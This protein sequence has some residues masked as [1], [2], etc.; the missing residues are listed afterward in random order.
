MRRVILIHGAGIPQMDA[1][2]G[3]WQSG[4]Q[5]ALGSGYE[6]LRPQMP[7]PENPHYE[8]WKARVEALLREARHEVVLVGHSLGGVVL[9]KYLAE[10]DVGSHI[11]G[12]FA[13]A[14]PWFGGEDKDWDVPQFALRDDLTRLERVP[15]ILLYHSRDDEVVPFAHLAI[16]GKHLPHATVRPFDDRGHYFNSRDF[17]EIIADIKG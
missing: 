3:D 7:D 16:Y 15:R 4:L 2:S 8:A 13:V 10:N 5:A 14:T 6:V 11:S 17:P 1:G 9:L 12:V